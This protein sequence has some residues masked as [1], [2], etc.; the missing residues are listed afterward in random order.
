MKN[1]P[2]VV[3]VFSDQH[4]MQAAGYSG[5]TNVNTPNMNRLK[6]TGV[7]FPYAIS[8][9]PVCCPNRASLLTGQYP[10]THKVIYN[11]V[12]LSESSISFA[13]TFKESGYDTAYIGKWHL[14]GK[15]RSSYIPPEERMGF[16]Y[17]RVL[18]CTHSYNR[19]QYY[20]I[21]NNIETWE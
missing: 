18:E 17:W 2:N 15:G 8:N 21:D 4:R 16:D 1:K 5:D 12:H 11:D 6:S 20:G 7:N 3:L 14:N 9:C 13:N 10:L 19:S